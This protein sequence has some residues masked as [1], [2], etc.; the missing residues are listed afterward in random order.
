LPPPS[1]SL[2]PPP[3]HYCPMLSFRYAIIRH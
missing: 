3:L 1:F 2:M